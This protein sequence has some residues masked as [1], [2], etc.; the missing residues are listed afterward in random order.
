LQDRVKELPPN[1]QGAFALQSACIQQSL[2]P[3]AFEAATASISPD[4]IAAHESVAKEAREHRSK[5][6][7]AFGLVSIPEASA[8]VAS[9]GKSLLTEALRGD[10]AGAQDGWVKKKTAD[11]RPYWHNTLT[12][13]TQWKEPSIHQYAAADAVT[14]ESKK[15]T[16]SYQVGEDVQVFSATSKTWCSGT[17]IEVTTKKGKDVAKVKYETN[18]RAM[19]KELLV[20]DPKLRK[21][22]DG[23]SSDTSALEGKLAEAGVPTYT[24]GQSVEVFSKTTKQW[25][26]GRVEKVDPGIVTVVYGSAGGYKSRKVLRATDGDLR[27]SSDDKPSESPY[28]AGQNVQVYSNGAKD[29]L[30]ARVKSVENGI[31]TVVY[32][33]ANGNQSKMLRETDKDLRQKEQY[34]TDNHG[35]NPLMDLGPKEHWAMK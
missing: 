12:A 28:Q 27:P 5:R 23:S 6:Q 30:D 18:G 1:M 31:V 10:A 11:G 3:A 33:G 26:K 15:R 4:E 20:Q 21:R 35:Q 32:S 9:A 16:K 13:E 7:Q 24:V 25:S 17:V 8:L 22:K 14:Q 2:G 34:K 29:W 19:T